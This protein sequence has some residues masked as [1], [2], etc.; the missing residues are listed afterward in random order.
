M[1]TKFEFY[2]I[3]EVI[4]LDPIFSEIAGLEGVVLGMA[5]DDSG[6]WYYSVLIDQKDETW[7]IPGSCLETTGKYRSREDIYGG[8]SVRV[9][10]NGEGEG[11]IVEN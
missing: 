3:V 2:E 8:D 9:T 7:N 4:A 5:E 10:V 11:K 1:V 6:D